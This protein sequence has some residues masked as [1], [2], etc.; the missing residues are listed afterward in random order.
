[1]IAPETVVRYGWKD[2][3]TGKG[4]NGGNLCCFCGTVVT[5]K[6]RSIRKTCSDR[7][8]DEVTVRVGS[9]HMRYVIE[10]RDKGVCALCKTD[11]VK[12]RLEFDRLRDKLKDYSGCARSPELKAILD[13]YGIP[14]G[15]VNGDWWDVDH[16]N[17]VDDGGGQC[18]K[19]NLRTLCIP[20]HQ[21]ATREW[22]RAKARARS[23]Q[24]ELF[25]EADSSHA[26]PQP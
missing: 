7:C 12:A 26:S 22:R 9:S 11:T 21:N 16:I 5:G 6:R 14:P 19:D 18:G 4:P 17:P 1:M 13:K 20:C 23:P 3:F 2:R 24:K 25:M 15:R 8:R 10:R